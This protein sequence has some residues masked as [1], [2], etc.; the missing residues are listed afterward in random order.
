MKINKY[1][2]GFMALGFLVGL[3]VSARE[4]SWGT[5]DNAV[6]KKILSI[7]D[8][9]AN[10]SSGKY[11]KIDMDT[12]NFKQ[13]KQELLTDEQNGEKRCAKAHRQSRNS[14]EAIGLFFKITHDKKKYDYIYE[15]MQ[16]EITKEDRNSW[17]QYIKDED[18]AFVFA[19]VY[20]NDYTEDNLNYSEAC[21]YHNF[22][23]LRKNGILVKFTF[24]HT[25]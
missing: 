24:N 11:A 10:N 16:N 2:F 17:Y 15:C 14:S 7:A 5:T 25:D 12:V 18:N 13:L 4:I 8:Q 19:S 6:A 9:C 20:R 1:V 23:V 3:S 21:L 22:Y